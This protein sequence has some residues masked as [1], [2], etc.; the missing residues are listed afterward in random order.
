MGF[1]GLAPARSG[2]SPASRCHDHTSR[3]WRRG[4]RPRVPA[5]AQ[6]INPPAGVAGVH[7]TYEEESGYPHRD[8]GAIG[9]EQSVMAVKGR[10]P[11]AVFYDS[12]TTL[13]DW[14]W[15]WATAA[16]TLVRKDGS[17]VDTAKVTPH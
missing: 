2:L 8:I 17:N 10:W 16:A 1:S 5:T 9:E 4:V 3:N 13:F 6:T 14:G 12:K 7:C 11:R 15:S